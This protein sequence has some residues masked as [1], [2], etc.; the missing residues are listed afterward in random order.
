MAEMVRMAWMAERAAIQA[1]L[2]HH[3]TSLGHPG[4]PGHLSNVCLRAPV[5]LDKELKILVS[6]YT[7]YRHSTR[8]ATFFSRTTTFSLKNRGWKLS[9]AN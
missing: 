1:I 6:R 8:F 9:Q 2:S 7:Y 3:R 5:E 4:H